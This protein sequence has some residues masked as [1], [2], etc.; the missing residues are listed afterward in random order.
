MA[1]LLVLPGLQASRRS[2]GLGC[3]GGRTPEEA[4]TWTGHTRQ[5]ADLRPLHQ[6]LQVGSASF[7]FCFF[8][9]AFKL[10]LCQYV[11]VTHSGFSLRPLVSFLDRRGKEK[12]TRI[13]TFHQ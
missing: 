4:A 2:E 10:V 3:P 13:L 11:S 9:S 6:L 8:L 7:L 1:G 5:A 12:K